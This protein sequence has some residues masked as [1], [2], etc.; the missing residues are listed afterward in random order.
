M[1]GELLLSNR[2]LGKS[3]ELGQVTIELIVDDGGDEE[4]EEEDDDDEETEDDEEDMSEDEREGEAESE[5]ID[6]GVMR[7]EGDGVVR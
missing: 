6:G 4:E 2:L 5:F 1:P 7:D 3:F